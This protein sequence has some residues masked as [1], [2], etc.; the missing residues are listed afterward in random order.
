M[1]KMKIAPSKPKAEANNDA[2]TEMRADNSK[3]ISNDGSNIATNEALQQVVSEISLKRKRAM[4]ASDNARKLEARRKA[5]MSWDELKEKNLN[6]LPGGT[7]IQMMR[8]RQE[9]DKAREKHLNKKR[10]KKKEEKEEEKEKKKKKK[11]RRRKRRRQNETVRG[12]HPAMKI[13]TATV[14]AVAAVTMTLMEVATKCL[15]RI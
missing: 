8:Y 6:E 10:K 3:A 11:R 2:T 4:G 13:R 15:F 7:T 12:N 5:M 9:L 1:P 14:V